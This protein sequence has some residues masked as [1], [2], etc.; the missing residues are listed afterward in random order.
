MATVTVCQRQHQCLRD[1]FFFFLGG[2]LPFGCP[3]GWFRTITGTE[4]AISGHSQ[5]ENYQWGHL[6]QIHL[7]YV[8][9]E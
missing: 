6:G 4:M 5:K 1:N 3:G 2:G 8:F 9:K 7:T